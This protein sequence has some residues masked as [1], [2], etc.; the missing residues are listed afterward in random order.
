MA[1][2]LTN[3]PLPEPEYSTDEERGDDEDAEE[4]QHE[5]ND[6]MWNLDWWEF[7]ENFVRKY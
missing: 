6:R 4:Q 7:E 2:N 3:Y 1:C 5:Q